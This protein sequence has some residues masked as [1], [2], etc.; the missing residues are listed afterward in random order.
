MVPYSAMCIFVIS[1]FTH[2][3]DM[4]IFLRKKTAN[5][6]KDHPGSEKITS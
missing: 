3:A 1:I 4:Q 2:N 5:L 6:L